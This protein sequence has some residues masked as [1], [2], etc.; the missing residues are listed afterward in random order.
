MNLAGTHRVID[1]RRLRRW[2]G[3]ILFFAVAIIAIWVVPR[4]GARSPIAIV[5]VCV[6]AILTMKLVE[7]R[8]AW[9]FQRWAQREAARVQRRKR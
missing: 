2:I 8:V 7:R 4:L 1:D 5:I 9:W 3:V 6:L